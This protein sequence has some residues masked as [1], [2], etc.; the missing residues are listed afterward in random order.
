MAA[1][2]GRSLL[3]FLSSRGGGAGA[4]G[5]GALT[6][7]CFPGLG[8]SRPRQQ[9]HHRTVSER[10][11]WLRGGRGGA[12]VWELPVGRPPG[13]RVSYLNSRPL[14]G[15]PGTE[16]PLCPSGACGGRAGREGER[17]KPRGRGG[18]ATAGMFPQDRGHQGG[19]GRDLNLSLTR[20]RPRSLPP[21]FFP[22][23]PRC[24]R[25]EPCASCALAPSTAGFG[26]PELARPPVCVSG[27]GPCLLLGTV[28]GGHAGPAGPLPGPRSALRGGARRE[29]KLCPSRR[30]PACVGTG[31][32]ALARDAAL[33]QEA[34]SIPGPS[35]SRGSLRRE[36]RRVNF[37]VCL[38]EEGGQQAEGSECDKLFRVGFGGC[39]SQLLLVFIGW[40]GSG[41]LCLN[42][43]CVCV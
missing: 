31:N 14:P 10:A 33:L 3:L 34:G 30:L 1:A 22:A 40:Q 25:P 39:L 18:G 32:G 19:E 36:R 15:L 20:P 43:L 2:A 13:Q 6:A 41:S 28:P 16:G 42:S 35:R 23:L 21:A 38:E 17:R 8:V 12:G 9:Q 37:S 4:G 29:I 11:R 5:C 27:G 24:S 26:R 7:G